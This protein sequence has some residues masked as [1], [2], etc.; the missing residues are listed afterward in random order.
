MMAPDY[1]R[2]VSGIPVGAPGDTCTHLPE[3]KIV[4]VG[5]DQGRDTSVGI[6]LDERLLLQIPKLVGLHFI[7]E[8]EFLNN[9]DDLPRVDGVAGAVEHERLQVGHVGRRRCVNWGT[10]LMV[11]MHQT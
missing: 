11:K 9:E 4:L 2:C 6:E 5:I 8:A 10:A 3:C 7:R 1:D